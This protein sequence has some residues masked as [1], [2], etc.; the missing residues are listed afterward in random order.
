MAIK[1]IFTIKRVQC[2]RHIME[3]MPLESCKE[4]NFFNGWET[5]ENDNITGADCIYAEIGTFHANVTKFEHG[6]YEYFSREYDESKDGPLSKPYH[7]CEKCCF[8]KTLSN[9]NNYCLLRQSVP[10]DEITCF[11][12]YEGE[13]WDKKQIYFDEDEENYDESDE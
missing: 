1:K 13:I 11:N 9:G 5:D 2:P 10:S 6:D 7:Y 4:C 8:S 12:C 3:G